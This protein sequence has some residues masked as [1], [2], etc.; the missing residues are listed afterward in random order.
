V[1]DAANTVTPIVVAAKSAIRIFFMAPPH[2]RLSLNNS[3]VTV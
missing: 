3:A 2:S 1:L